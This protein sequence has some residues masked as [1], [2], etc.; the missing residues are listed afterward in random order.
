MKRP[1]TPTLRQKILL[2][3]SRLNPANWLVVWDK[4]GEMEVIHRHGNSRKVLKKGGT[5]PDWRG[6]IIFRG[7]EE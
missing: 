3:Y 6:E 4:P 5:S 7:R 1:S 2:K